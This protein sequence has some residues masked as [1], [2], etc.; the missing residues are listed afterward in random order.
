MRFSS[1]PIRNILQEAVRYGGII[2][3]VRE[4]EEFLKGHIPMAVNVPL[5]DIKAG[6]FSLPKS[7]YLLLYCTY[8]GGSTMASRILSQEG[9]K[10]I[11]TIGGL[12]QYTGAL[13]K[14]R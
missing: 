1:I 7:R 11:N 10:V 5:D 9:Y 6:Q 2:V 4:Q 14:E 8:G 3:D 12:V 13:T